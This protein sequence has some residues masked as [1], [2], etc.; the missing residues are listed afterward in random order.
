MSIASI[1][2]MLQGA[3]AFL[4]SP[5][6]RYVGY[7]LIALAVY[8]AG[9]LRGEQRADLRCQTSQLQAEADAKQRD[10]DAAADASD[11]DDRLYKQIEANAKTDKEKIRAY[12]SELAHRKN[13]TCVI[14]ADDVR[15]LRPSSTR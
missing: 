7:G 1:L 11:D 13:D 10:L 9:F 2:T 5:V 15:R 12:Q 4:T 3:W 14:N 6:G 8:G